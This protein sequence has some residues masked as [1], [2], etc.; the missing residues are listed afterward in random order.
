MFRASKA[1]QKNLMQRETYRWLHMHERFMAAKCCTSDHPGPSSFNVGARLCV[2]STPL[3]LQSTSPLVAHRHYHCW[4]ANT[5]KHLSQGGIYTPLHTK[6]H[7]RACC[8]D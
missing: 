3:Q 6:A 1:A 8:R 5:S 7:G 2:S 4:D